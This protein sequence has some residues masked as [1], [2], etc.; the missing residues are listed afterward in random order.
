M[1]TPP[2]PFRSHEPLPLPRAHHPARPVRSVRTQDAGECLYAP[3]RGPHGRLTR[4]ACNPRT[5]PAHE[6][7][8]AR[9]HPIRIPNSRARGGGQVHAGHRVPR[10]DDP[11]AN[12]VSNPVMGSRPIRPQIRRRI[13]T[14]PP[15]PA[16]AATARS[17]AGPRRE[18]N[19][20]CVRSL[21]RRCREPERRTRSRRRAAP[22]SISR[23][24]DRYARRRFPPHLPCCVIE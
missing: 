12:L 13:A 3:V 23:S 9:P 10:R 20:C 22:T 11:D 1:G 7:R 21:R 6:A 14:P 24:R 2:R 4:F 18:S 16:P 15:Q 19:P 8:R 17:I 5:A